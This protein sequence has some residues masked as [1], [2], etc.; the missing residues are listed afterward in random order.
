MSKDAE[1]PRPW[2]MNDETMAILLRRRPDLKGKTLEEA[3]AIIKAQYPGKKRVD[4]VER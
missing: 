1:Q 4:Q 3:K 2:E